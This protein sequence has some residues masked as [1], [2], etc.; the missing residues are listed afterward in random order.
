MLKRTANLNSPAVARARLRAALFYARKNRR[1]KLPIPL[2]LFALFVP[3]G[4]D[5]LVTSDGDTFM[6]RV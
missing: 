6:V 5:A 1:N 2:S 4:S 3:Q